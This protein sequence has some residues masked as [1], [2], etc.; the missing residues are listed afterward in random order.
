MF[1]VE[2]LG[3]TLKTWLMMAS[4]SLCFCCARWFSFTALAFFHVLAETGNISHVH[5]YS[6]ILWRSPN[7]FTN[8]WYSTRSTT[9]GIHTGIICVTF[10]YCCNI[11]TV[12]QEFLKK[13]HCSYFFVKLIWFCLHR[14]HHAE[15]NEQ[16]YFFC[17][18]KAT[19]IVLRY[20]AKRITKQTERC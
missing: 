2:K 6:K 10:I 5:V 15:P 11:N 7:T 1:T 18:C 17:W 4:V 14:H 3:Q 13:W 16:V 20:Q 12:Y 9:V 19:A 8:Y